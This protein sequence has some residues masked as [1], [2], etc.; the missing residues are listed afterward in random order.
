MCLDLVTRACLQLAVGLAVCYP[1]FADGGAQEPQPE[2]PT[3]RLLTLLPLAETVGLT[4]H[5]PYHRGGEMISAAQLAVDKINMRDDIL[6]GY[7][8]ELIPANSETCNQSLVTEALGNFV[9]HVTDGGLNI[10]GVVG[11]VCST[12]TQA[13]SPLAGRPEIDLLQIS[14]GAISPVFTSEEVY[15]RL[16]RMIPS[17]AVYNDAVLELMNAFNWNRISMVRDAILIQH[18][19]TADDFVSKVEGRTELELV[20]L[21]DVTAT[22]LTSLVQSL[23]Q[24]TARII[25]ASV[26]PSEARE[27]LC[28]SYHC[29]SDFVWLFHDLSIEELM[30]HT[31]KCDNEAM[32]RAIEGVFLLRYRPQPHP[33]NTLVSGQT[34]SEYVMQLQDRMG[35]TQKNQHAN[36]LHDSIWAFAL[37]LNNSL[38]RDPGLDPN[39]ITEVVESNLRNLTF[40]GALG[41]IAFNEEREVVIDVDIFHLRAG[42]EIHIGHYSPITGNIA[43]QLP[44]GGIPGDGAE[45]IVIS[46]SRAFPIIVYVIIAVLLI[47]TTVVLV[48]YIYY[49][50]KPS[51][52]STSPF[53][54][55]LMFAGCYI[56]YIAAV[57]VATAEIKFW[58]FMCQLEMWCMSIGMQLIY[59][60]LFMRLLR[61][62]RLLLCR[63]F[64]KPG[65]ILSDQAIL[66]QI[67]IP[68]SITVLL[69]VLWTSLE[70]SYKAYILVSGQN[71]G[72]PLFSK[73][74]GGQN[75]LF[76]ALFMIFGVN[77]TTILAVA[78]IAT[79]TRKVH[80][81]CFKDSR[82]VNLFVFSTVVCLLIW[83]PY[84]ITFN[85]YIPIIGVS[86]FFGVFPYVVI[87]FLCLVFLF[88][89]KI[90]LSRHQR[91]SRAR[92]PSERRSTLSSQYSRSSIS[93]QYSKST[94]APQ[95]SRSSISNSIQSPPL[96]PSI[97]G[98]AFQTVF[99]VHPCTP[100]FLH[101]KMSSEHRSF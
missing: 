4:H 59:S 34:Y 98:P 85:F 41:K 67:C 8:L 66:V 28:E 96:H 88:V 49:W 82:K 97:Q 32:L 5:P 9:R 40:S 11:L 6:P 71:C 75:F 23:L 58:G 29:Q 19:T 92:T 14:A 62:Y 50:N 54:S 45:R 44:S 61:V 95:Y 55:L 53:L 21:G 60:T 13:I 16:Y 65:S 70:P 37:A 83:L 99:K 42:E 10:V 51:I 20:Y 101:K 38:T 89:P 86:F 56:L 31:E 7:K 93:K 17:S 36:A 48:L 57:V 35:R 68:I 77:G 73:I 72:P 25:Y 2:P 100:V 63:V 74:C 27:L 80:L 90:W 18:S 12:V 69:L 46:I 43:V 76:W 39:N 33:N 52:K 81:E 3:L 30:V 78:V 47:F 26:T 24:E 87:P 84:T 91:R 79:L 94:L 1:L 15:P 22:F 64:D